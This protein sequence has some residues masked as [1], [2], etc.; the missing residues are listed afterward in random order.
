MAEEREIAGIR[1]M[2]VL[3]LLSAYV[4]GEL[5]AAERERID[6]HLK[7]C[8]NC[9]RFGGEFSTMLRAVGQKLRPPGALDPELAQ[10]LEAK[11]RGRS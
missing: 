9:L 5:N 7:G 6:G 4:D 10:R 1:C 8:D 2:E 3:G 11:L